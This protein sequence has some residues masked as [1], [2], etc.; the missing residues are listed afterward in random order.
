MVFP[1]ERTHFPGV[2]KIG[3]PISGPRIAD[4]KNFTD[5]K[6]IFLNGLIMRG[7]QRRLTWRSLSSSCRWHTSVSAQKAGA[8]TPPH[9]LPKGPSCTKNATATQNIVNYYAIA[10]LLRPPYFRK[11][12]APIKIKSALPPP[13]KPPLKRRNF[14]DTGFPAERTLFFQVSIKLAASHFRPQNC[15]H[16]FYG[17]GDFSEY[18]LLRAPLLERIQKTS[19]TPQEKRVS[20]EGAPW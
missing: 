13:P 9:Y 11:I 12:R 2:H 3:A 7:S 15:G 8:L 16:E 1:A 5:T 4:T 6:R 19:V 17:H 20:A 18:L 10:F 14:T